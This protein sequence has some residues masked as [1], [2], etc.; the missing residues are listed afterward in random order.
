MVRIWGPIWGNYDLG[1]RGNI[2]EWLSEINDV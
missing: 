2:R 1:V